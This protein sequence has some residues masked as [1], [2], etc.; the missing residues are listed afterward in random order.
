TMNLGTG[1]AG[2]YLTPYALDP[3]VLIAGP[4]SVDP[5]R[6]VA[7]NEMTIYN[8]QRFVTSTQVAASWD[9]EEQEVSDDSPTLSQPPIVCRKGA[10]FVPVSFELFEDSTIAAQVGTL[11]AD[12]KAQLESSAFTLGNGTTEPKGVITAV[13][14][15]GSSI[16]TTGTNTV[17]VSDLFTN[18]SALP[19]PRP[20]D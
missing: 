10:A 19:P 14:A 8:E 9:P 16:I 18:Q 13:S 5:M 20:P 12:A 6:A 4:G 2:G 15:V 11:F 1:S 17:A 7:R 3:N